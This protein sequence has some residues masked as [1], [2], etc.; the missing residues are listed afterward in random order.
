MAHGAL[1]DGQ[2]VGGVITKFIEAFVLPPGLFVAFMA[3]L[4]GWLLG[5]RK[6]RLE[7]WLAIGLAALLW[8]LSTQAVGELLIAPLERAYP[9]PAAAEACWGDAIVVL[10]GGTRS[11]SPAEAGA[12]AL[13]DE[14]TGRL[15]Y[16]VRLAREMPLP[17]IFTGG[18]ALGRAD[19]P[20]EAEAAERVARSLGI[21][22]KRFFLE[23]RSRTTWENARFVAEDFETAVPLLVTSAWHMPRA[24]YSFREHGMDPVPAPTLYMSDPSPPLPTDFVPS[25]GGF[26]TT[27]R[28]LHEYVGLIYYRLRR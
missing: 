17:L 6:A 14:S 11:S 19:R 1:R 10:G 22:G 5:R 25:A 20:S 8:I 2:A 12:P 3:L 21:E 13:T 15:V 28:A 24:I 26:E 7:G 27:S 18:R 4:G 9:P 23:E 16:G